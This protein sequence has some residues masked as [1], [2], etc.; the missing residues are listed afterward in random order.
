MNESQIKTIKARL[1]Q[2]KDERAEESLQAFL[3][4]EEEENMEEQDVLGE[5]VAMFQDVVAQ[6]VVQIDDNLLLR[7][8]IG[9]GAQVVAPVGGNL[10]PNDLLDGSTE[11]NS[12]IQLP[13]LS[14]RVPS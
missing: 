14:K 2:D 13:I 8:M 9:Q 1:L 11:G 12:T 3:E 7:A 5:V 6:Q 10:S 4:E